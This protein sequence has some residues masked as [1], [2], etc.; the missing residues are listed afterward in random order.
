MVDEY[1]RVNAKPPVEGLGRVGGNLAHGMYAYGCQALGNARAHA[2]EVRDGTVV[3]ERGA[4]CLL[5]QLAKEVPAVLGGD[6][7]R[8]LCQVEVGTKPAGG[9]DASGLHHIL[10]NAL[11]KL[12]RR[13]TVEVEI[14]RD[15]HEGLV[16]RVD[17]DV[18]RGNPAQVDRIDV[19]RALHVERHSRRHH[20]VVDGLGDLEDAAAVAHAQRLHGRRDRKAD[21]L[22]SARG[23]GHHEARR[24]RVKAALHALNAGVE[25]LEVYAEVLALLCARRKGVCHASARA[26]CGA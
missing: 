1:L 25:A 26:R 22:L 2:P 18:F 24:E 4:I 12:A 16:Y 11:T 17:V 13:A 8:N 19:T 10:A 9:G 20:H 7:E 23:I 21:G 3:P 5:V 15:V 6:V 14:A